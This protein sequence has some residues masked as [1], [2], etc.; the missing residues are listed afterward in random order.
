MATMAF[1]IGPV[2]GFFRKTLPSSITVMV[3]RLVRWFFS[4]MWL[5]ICIKPASEM[6]SFASLPG[7]AKT[8]N[9]TMVTSTSGQAIPGRLKSSP[10]IPEV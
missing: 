7:R 5:I 9:S 6:A 3:L 10:S 4:T 2:S 1:N 8:P